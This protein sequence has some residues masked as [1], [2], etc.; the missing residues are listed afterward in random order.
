[1]G[2][3]GIVAIILFLAAL[4]FALPNVYAA[5][6][7]AYTVAG[8]PMSWDGT[9]ANRLKIPTVDYDYT[10]GDES[11][12]TY[13]LPW[14]F[15]FYGNN[16][17]R[18]T[19]DTNGNIWFD[20]R[21]TGD[22]PTLS[23][24]SNSYSLTTTGRG[25]VVASWNADLS[26]HYYGGVF[27]QHKTNPERVVVEWQTETYTDQ[28]L[29]R[30]NSFET[31]LYENGTIQSDYKFIDTTAQMD[32][33]SGISKDD[34]IHSSNL[35]QTFGPIY[36]SSGKSFQYLPPTPKIGVAPPSDSFGRVVVNRSSSAHS[37]NISNS[38]SSDLVFDQIALT[39]SDPSQ[40]SITANDCVSNGVSRSVPPSGSCVVDVQFAPI[41]AGAKTAQLSLHSNDPSAPI[42]DI[43]VNG[44]GSLPNLAT[45]LSG[46][47][48]GTI[49]SSPLPI[50]CGDGCAQYPVGT[51]VVL[52]ATPDNN[53]TFIGWTGGCSGTGSCSVVMTEDISVT[54][55]YKIL[56]PVADFL[57]STT[58]FLVSSPVSFT[59]LSVR[60]TSWLWNF[61]DGATSTLQ[62]PTHAYSAP[63]V[64]SVTLQVSNG[65]GSVSI[66]K[67]NLITVVTGT[68][69]TE[70][71]PYS[72]LPSGWSFGGYYA[73]IS[74]TNHSPGYGVQLGDGQNRDG[75]VGF[76]AP[77][78]GNLS[79]WYYKAST[80]GYYWNSDGEWDEYG[81]D[82]GQIVIRV[83]GVEALTITSDS[84]WTRT[85]VIPVMAGDH[86]NIAVSGNHD[87][88]G[89][90]C[91]QLGR[92]CEEGEDYFLNVSASIDDVSLVSIKEDITPAI[93]TA[94][95]SGG[96]VSTA[97][98]I[99]L[100]S[101]EPATIYYT[102]D[103][104]TPTANSSIYSA[105]I[106]ITAS[107]TIKF[108]SK[109]LAGN[110]EPVKSQLY[111]FA[112][113]QAVPITSI[114]PTGDYY[115]IPIAVTLTVNEPAA[116]YYTL[117]S[118][119][120]TT[121]SAVYTAPLTISQTTTVKYFAKD[122]TGNIEAVKVKTYHYGVNNI[123]LVTTATPPGG[124]YFAPQTVTLSAN[125]EAT[126]HY[127]VDGTAPHLGSP[128]YTYP[129][130]INGTTTLQYF[131]ATPS[132]TCESPHTQIYVLKQ[133]GTEFNEAF[134]AA[135]PVG[136]SIQ[137][138][139]AIS[140]I[141]HS[142]SYGLQVGD[143]VSNDGSA[144]FSAPLTGNL[145]FWYYKASRWGAYWDSRP[146]HSDGLG[147]NVGQMNVFVNGIKVLTVS[148]DAGWTKTPNIS[149]HSGDVVTIAQSGSSDDFGAMCNDDPWYCEDVG[150]PY[151]NVSVYID[152]I[153]I[154]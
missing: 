82:A 101:S 128:V 53:S 85:P 149:V 54:A 78:T 123:P 89:Y 136:W 86:I 102:T 25:P 127:T 118:T 62:N 61:G 24:T 2:K 96:T 34:G 58:T 3:I 12:V 74:S 27:V 6:E 69:Y 104:S 76:L 125:Q 57:P 109:D 51:S 17:S 131:A 21:I 9:E 7:G 116:I 144:T 88:E 48:G 46:T 4:N 94:S 33:G 97:Q 153:K 40:F 115:Q 110:L 141:N 91:G 8:V 64:Y 138:A 70:T 120:P 1:M 103:G 5:T 18:I 43:S 145:S 30:L 84:G 44:L 13:S 81:K 134:G 143:G 114:S 152:D 20:S 16:Y 122:T 35:S 65:S 111:T 47:G 59:D 19:A 68:S 42:V 31:I 148:D 117:D 72:F 105:P 129:I 60:G 90:Y 140:N 146:G 55:E 108:F 121:S 49:T 22:S 124:T 56:P 132:L 147:N 63:G 112:P 130:P 139:G 32:F 83:N 29:Y 98:L 95:P 38:G 99:T 23:G 93:T 66:T 10:Y 133:P 87:D 11:S 36:A 41:S 15:K 150:D 67:A 45:V 80:W 75:S 142:P 126:I 28:G 50:S 137:G 14:T 37:F 107:K 79:F 52:T 113:D 26:S 119:T 135:L 39:G 73:K 92:S 71:F 154:E 106:Y 100:T 77:V 151:Y